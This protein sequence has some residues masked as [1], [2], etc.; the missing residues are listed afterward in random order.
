MV[1]GQTP[2]LGLTH[3][4]AMTLKSGY[5]TEIVDATV[6]G[7]SNDELIKLVATGKYKYV[8]ITGSTIAFDSMS[9]LAAD[10]KKA[11]KEIVVIV[12]GAHFTAVPLESMNRC[13]DFDIGVVGEADYSIVELLNCLEINGDLHKITGIVFRKNGELVD[14]GQRPP[15][16]DLDRLPKPAWH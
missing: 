3:L 1:G 14:T 7:L 4:A 6:L 10:I 15:I 9:S 5:R 13:K 11:D 8:G 2:P 16:R 12:G